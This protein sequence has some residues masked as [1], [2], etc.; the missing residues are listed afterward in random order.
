MGNMHYREQALVI[1]SPGV[2]EAPINRQ[3]IDPLQH[4][5]TPRLPRELVSYST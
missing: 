1:Q 3:E 4:E 5:E 2:S